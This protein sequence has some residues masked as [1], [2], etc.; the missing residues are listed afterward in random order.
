MLRN[1][2]C[3]LPGVG[4]QTEQKLWRAGFTSWES[5]LLQAEPPPRYAVRPTCRA[6]LCESAARYEA[7]DPGYFAERLPA[8]Q[9][10]RLFPDFRAGCAY[11]DIETTG[12]GSPRDHITAV[13]IYDGGPPRWFVRGDNLEAVL[14]GDIA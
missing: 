13:A 4:S 6:A 3:H 9:R 10:W 2:F 12:L 8:N 11:L 14:L 5:L 1:T 7:G